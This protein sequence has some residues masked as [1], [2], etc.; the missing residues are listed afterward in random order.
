[1]V[2]LN[3]HTRN[4]MI[5]R[6]LLVFE[7]KAN[8]SHQMFQKKQNSPNIIKAKGNVKYSNKVEIIKLWRNGIKCSLV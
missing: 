3:Y 5:Q 4:C 7:I 6:M 2:T 1:M 8:C